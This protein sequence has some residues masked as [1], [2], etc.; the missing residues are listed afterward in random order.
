[1]VGTDGGV[2]VILVASWNFGCWSREV[3]LQW[4]PFRS[5]PKGSGIVWYGIVGSQWTSSGLDH[6]PEILGP[7]SVPVSILAAHPADK[8]AIDKMEP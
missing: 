8:I 3:T 4:N 5:Y 2:I 6:R 7:V 1:M